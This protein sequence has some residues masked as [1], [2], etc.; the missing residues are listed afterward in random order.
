LQAAQNN[1][2]PFI[3]L[4]ALLLWP[5]AVIVAS[6][7]GWLGSLSPFAPPPI[8]VLTILVPSLGYWLIPS[9]RSYITRIGLRRLTSVHILRI[10]AVPLFFWYGSHGL[11][12]QSFVDTAGWGDLASGVL[13]LGVVLFWSRPAGYWTVHIFGMVDFVAAFGT[14][15]RL[16]LSNPGAMHEITGLPMALIPFFGVGFLATI[17]L[18]AYDLLI[19]NCR[20]PVKQLLQLQ[21]TETL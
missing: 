9:F 10:V 12:P 18:I 19:R 2:T 14:A 8:A 21:P 1:R 4:A 17:H 5:T 13:A 7:S 3:L 15:I 11:L 16:T 20:G 6:K